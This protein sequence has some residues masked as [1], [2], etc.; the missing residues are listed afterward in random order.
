MTTSANQLTTE[1]QL[2]TQSPDLSVVIPALNEAENLKSLL[3]LIHEVVDDL[4]SRRKSSS[5][6]AGR[7]TIPD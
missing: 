7:R 1:S 4:G 3:P 6:M 5:S 2:E